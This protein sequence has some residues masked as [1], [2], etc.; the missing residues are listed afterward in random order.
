MAMNEVMAGEPIV[1]PAVVFTAAQTLT[2][3]PMPL[4]PLGTGDLLVRTIVTAI[5][6]IH[7]RPHTAFPFVPGDAAVGEVIAVGA[8][9]AAWRGTSVFVGRGRDAENVHAEAGVQSAWI[10]APM[11]ATVHP[12]GLLPEEAL[13]IAPVAM[14]LH[15]LAS[16]GMQ[17]G[18]RVCVLG[19]DVLGQMIARIAHLHDAAHVTVA[20]ASRFRLDRAV[21]DAA[22]FLPPHDVAVSAPRRDIDLLVDTTGDAAL[23]HS[24]SRWLRPGGTLLVLASV[25]RLDMAYLQQRRD[26]FRLLLAG[27]PDGT[28]YAIARTALAAGNLH[29]AG[30]VTHHFPLDRIAQAYAIALGD[31]DALHVVVE[32][33]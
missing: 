8:A 6:P 28:E 20:D 26:G 10:V 5:T 18:M 24:W 2:V 21:A 16:A 14:A 4:P 3:R 9:D 32:W 15:G 31:P 13:F 1:G 22:V 23:L 11:D 29:T 25:P 17:P 7:D 30:L 33:E 12:G 27:E 19:Q